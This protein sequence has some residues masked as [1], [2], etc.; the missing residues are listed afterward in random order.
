ME[1][2]GFKKLPSGGAFLE[3][4]GFMPFNGQVECCPVW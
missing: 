4:N 1:N 2:L 3:K